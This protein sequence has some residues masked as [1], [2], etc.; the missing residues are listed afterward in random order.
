LIAKFLKEVPTLPQERN[1]ELYSPL[2]SQP[3][4]K[5]YFARGDPPMNFDVCLGDWGVSSWTTKHLCEVIQPVAL[6][7]PEVLIRAPW[8]WTADWWNLGPVIL[9]VFRGVQMFTGQDSQD[10][11]YMLK[12]YLEEIVEFFGPFP[13]LLLDQGD[14]EIVCEMFND[15]GTIKGSEPSNRPGLVSD[16]YMGDLP[17]KTREDFVAFLHELMKINAKERLPTMDLLGQPWIRGRR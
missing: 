13:T 12:N 14:P 16:I 4:H 11:P 7:S 15:D 17:L 1:S 3:L 8:D 10:S 9:E 6:R 2:R 5:S